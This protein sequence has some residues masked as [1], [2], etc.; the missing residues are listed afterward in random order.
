MCILFNKIIF[1]QLLRCNL[2]L[3]LI[4]YSIYILIIS[5]QIPTRC[6]CIFKYFAFSF[7]IMY[8][9]H[10]I[11]YY[12]KCLFAVSFGQTYLSNVLSYAEQK[13][14]HTLFVLNLKSS[15]TRYPEMLN[16]YTYIHREYRISLSH[17]SSIVIQ[18]VAISLRLYSGSATLLFVWTSR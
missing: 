13:I 4:N 12:G 17:A 6:N 10:D 2:I 3:M 15:Y 1:L 8:S 18:Q 9:S 14:R 11:R 7:C 16:I 5:Y